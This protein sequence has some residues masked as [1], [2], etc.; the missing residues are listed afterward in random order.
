MNWLSENKDV[1][2]I[3]IA[4][5]SLIISLA[6]WIR[7]ISTSRTKVKIKPTPLKVTLRSFSDQPDTHKFHLE[8]EVIN[9]SIFPITI[10]ES[11]IRLNGVWENANL[12]SSDDDSLPC[13]IDGRDV[14]KL[15]YRS[16]NQDPSDFEAISVI[17]SDD[18]EFSLKGRTLRKILK[19]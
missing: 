7:S 12:V 9:K 18:K 4:V 16:E 11:K 1:I 19:G 17:L 3:T 14:M 13:R 15:A 8:F 10:K 6:S 2:A 5:I